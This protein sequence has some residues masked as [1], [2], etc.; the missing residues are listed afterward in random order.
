MKALSELILDHMIPWERLSWPLDLDACFP[1]RA[2]LAVE[3]GFGDG[4]FILDQA[5]RRPDRNH[6]AIELAWGQVDRLLGKLERSGLD[7]LRVMNADA[8]LVL[9]RMIQSAAV[10]EFFIN[11]PDPWPK[12][13]HHGRRLIQPALLRELARG[14]KAGGLVEIATDHADYAAWI[15][16][17]LEQQHELVSDLGVT[18]V[19]ELPDRLVTRY[20]MKARQVGIDNHFFV[21]R[22]AGPEAPPI[23]EER[24]EEMPNVAFRGRVAMRELLRDFQPLVAHERHKNVDLVIHLIRAFRQADEDHWLV[25]ALVKEGRFHQQIALSVVA[26]EEGRLTVKASSIGYPRPTQGLKRAV[27]HL[28]RQIKLRAPGLEVDTSTVGPLED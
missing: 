6:V 27:W 7:N 12:E 1:R 2:P 18:E 5:R 17:R 15:G 16:A 23:P 3:I 21:W 4:A 19:A 13:R 26:L 8:S 10:S 20:Q 28:A 25:E 24:N 22:K 11:H 14:L 9:E